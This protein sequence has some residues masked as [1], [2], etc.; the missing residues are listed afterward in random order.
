MGYYITFRLFC[1]VKTRKNAQKIRIKIF[2]CFIFFCPFRT[3][4]E[5]P[6]ARSKHATGI[7]FKILGT[8]THAALQRQCLAAH[9]LEIGGSQRN[10][11]ATNLLFGVAVV[12]HRRHLDVRLER[13]GICLLELLQL[14][15]PS[16]G[17]DNVDV[18]TVLPP[19]GGRYAGQ[20]TD[21]LLGSCISTLAKTTLSANGGFRLR[22]SFTI[23]PR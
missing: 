7:P 14:C 6:V 13:L 21:T 8:Q 1:Q 12:T 22:V 19:L 23:S 5:R 10:A 20:T 15:R 2:S 9:I 16:Q 18:D 17:A 4:K 11:S 3:K